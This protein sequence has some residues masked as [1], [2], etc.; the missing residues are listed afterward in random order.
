MKTTRQRGK[1][2]GKLSCSWS[3][4]SSSCCPFQ[5]SVCPSFLNWK[6]RE[7]VG[8]QRRIMMML[9]LSSHTRSLFTFCNL[10][11]NSLTQKSLPYS[12]DRNTYNNSDYSLLNQTT[13]CKIKAHKISLPISYDN[14]MILLYFSSSLLYAQAFLGNDVSRVSKWS[15]INKPL[16]TDNVAHT[17][18]PYSM[19]PFCDQ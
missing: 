16:F 19:D 18:T 9:L 12:L 4:S 7:M 8:T 6:G 2:S 1:S 5:R 3:Y 11:R 13:N 14:L 17:H 15:S 10:E